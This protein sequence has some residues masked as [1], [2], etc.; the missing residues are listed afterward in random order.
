MTGRDLLAMHGPTLLVDIGFD[1][2]WRPSRGPIPPVPQVKSIGALVDTGASECCIDDA[3]AVKL[4]LPVVDKQKVSGASG[5]WMAS[6]YLA[7]V[8][9]PALPF[10]MWGRFAGVDL[11]G[12]GQ[13]HQALIGRTFLRN[14]TMTY[15]GITGTV[16]L[17]DCR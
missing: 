14:V 10:T 12:G 4:G 5:A 16:I 15:D 3:L 9:V 8:H 6:F 13:A 11:T 17:D 2:A 7:Q 1:P